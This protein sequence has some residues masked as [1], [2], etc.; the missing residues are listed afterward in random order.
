MTTPVQ[1]L[2]E[3][4]RRFAA[5]PVRVRE[6]VRDAMEKGAIDCVAEMRRAAPF[7]DGDLRA[8]INWS[9]GEAPAGAMVIGKVAGNEYGSMRITIFAGGGDAFYARF[10]EFGTTDMRANPFFYPVWRVW[11]RRI[12]ARITR[13]MRKAIRESMAA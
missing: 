4:E 3:F 1:G 7:K 9:W 6:A 12:R 5:I 2:A 8:S 10:Q 11:R 13:A